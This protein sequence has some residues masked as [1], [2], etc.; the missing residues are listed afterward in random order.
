MIITAP[1]S[2]KTGAIGIVIRDYESMESC[3][4]VSK[5]IHSLR[6]M[7]FDESNWDVQGIWRSNKGKEFKREPYI[8]TLCVPDASEIDTYREHIERLD[9][10]RLID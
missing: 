4:A 8:V 1:A 5:Y 10:Y 7:V 3:E 2:L 6:G 9:R